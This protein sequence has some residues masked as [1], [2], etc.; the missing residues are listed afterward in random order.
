[1]ALHSR[2][3]H[4]TATEVFFDPTGRRW[5]RTKRWAAVFVVSVVVLFGV[6][7]VQI[8]ASPALPDTPALSPL[9]ELE[10]I[11]SPPFVGAGPLVRLVRIEHGSDGTVAVDPLS[12][13]PVATL[14]ASD[15]A[16]VGSSR[17]ALYRYGLD[18]GVHKTIL[19]TFDDGPDPHWTPAILDL[20]SQHGVP[21]TF[22]VVGSAVVRHPDI[23][24]RQLRE[25]H[26]VG[27][28][29]TT[30][31]EV[32][33]PVVAQ[34]AAT[35]DR[36]L[37][38]TT[39][40]RT[41]LFRLP[42]YGDDPSKYNTEGQPILEAQRL[43]YLVSI[44]DFDSSDWKYGDPATRPT[45]PVPLPSASQDN[46]TLLVHDG[47]GNRAAT[48]EYLRR[49]IPWAQAHGYTFHSLPQVSSEVR[50][51]TRNKAPSLGDRETLWA[52]QFRWFVADDLL[53]LLFWFAV[54]SVVLGGLLNVL[55]AVAR[56]VIGG[57]RS[58]PR[59]RAP[60][61]TAVVPAYNE[62]AV[63]AQCL[64]ALCRS[65][66]P[67]LV[68]I[69]VVDDGSTDDT[70]GVVAAMAARD[71]RIR[72][73][74]QPNRGKATALNRAF[75][76]ATTTVVV[77][78]DAD[79]VFTP[80]TVSRL[81]RGFATD[82]RGRLGAVA[83]NVK[84]G[85]LGN[86]LTRW[87]ALEYIMQIG[88]DRCA[89][90]LLRA[91]VVV[92][93][94]CAAWRRS[95]VIR[96]R[97]FSPATA[98][99]DCDLALQLQQHGY[100]VAQNLQAVAFTE[101]PETFRQLSRQRFRWTYGN[102]QALWK[103]RAM[104]LNPRYGWLGLFSLPSAALSIVMPIVFLPFVYAM[105]AVTLNQDNGRLLLVYAAIFLAVQL[106]QA[107]AGVALT[108]ERPVHLL[109]VPIYRLIGEPLRAYLLYK[110]AVMAL[111]GT[112]TGWHKA[113]RRGT[114]PASAPAAAEVRS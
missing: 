77:T 91:I 56:A 34:E 49:L 79:T 24:N 16:V 65:R 47:G 44:H 26:A 78:L 60:P 21:A 50:A 19:L 93:G 74:R 96:C 76:E 12:G 25:G 10:G 103:H 27:N 110:C 114:V 4:Q 11:D 80:D 31:P 14:S 51:R 45:S 22:F 53:N 43:G 84:V 87:Q 28:H 105:A 55:L 23:V 72:L 98:A 102:A 42:Y 112:R 35:A 13:G 101:A 104:I 81:A 59:N 109:I 73:I 86:L 41:D 95:A 106:I 52:Y 7:W 83:G 70:A 94:A 67:N 2:G 111:R 113:T 38:A 92:P 90:E 17:Y 108:G 3:N 48:L 33:V 36:I 61:V 20:L 82:P 1:V 68:E 64:T 9:P 5:R 18:Q 46:I 30:H 88:V 89:Q 107:A 63:I 97:G 37:T 71:R 15:V 40:V 99:E 58:G 39:R 57:R 6:S 32:T 8:Q 75:V 66:Y 54:I 100:R 29:T 85:N 69:I 62:Q